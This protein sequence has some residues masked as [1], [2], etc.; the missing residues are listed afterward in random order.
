MLFTPKLVAPERIGRGIGWVFVLLLGVAV[1]ASIGLPGGTQTAATPAAPGIVEA[2][3]A[4][5]V[6]ML[7]GVIETTWREAV[8]DLTRV[9]LAVLDFHWWPL[10]V[11]MQWQDLGGDSVLHS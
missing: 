6:T 1:I 8:R 2:G 9:V 11:V 3:L 5:G 10:Q 7:V 4:Q